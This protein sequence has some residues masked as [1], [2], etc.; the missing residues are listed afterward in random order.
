MKREFAEAA[1]ADQHEYIAANLLSLAALTSRLLAKEAAG[2]VSLSEAGVLRALLDG[3]RRIT[4]LAEVEGLA[5][6]TMTLLVK[7]LEEQG[8]VKRERQRDDERVVL[9]RLTAARRRAL[10][11]FRRRLRAV[12]RTHL[13][14]MPDNQINAL[15]TATEALGELAAALLGGTPE[16]GASR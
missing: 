13:E 4:E 5:Q 6:P 11:D 10:E 12:L 8:S 15:A 16:R 9:V 14:A 7:R 2:G 3:P 1:Q